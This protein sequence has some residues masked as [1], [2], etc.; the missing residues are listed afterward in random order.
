[1]FL[2][3]FI[4]VAVF[5]GVLHR[6]RANMNQDREKV[7]NGERQRLISHEGLAHVIMEAQESHDLPSTRWTQESQWCDPS[8]SSEHE[9]GL[10]LLP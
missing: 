4:V 9:E 5:V 7:R 6:N 3:T 8:L 10:V 1:M 2:V